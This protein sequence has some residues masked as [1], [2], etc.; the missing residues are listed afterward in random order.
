M[1]DDFNPDEYIKSKQ[2]DEFNPD[3]YIKN[4]GS[5]EF[6][7]D[8]YLNEK[9]KLETKPPSTITKE[10]LDKMPKWQ[11]WLLTN[12]LAGLNS[13]SYGQLNLG[14][15][16]GK[17][18]TTL[19]NK[20]HPI[21]N[22]AGQLEGFIDSPF[23]KGIT[24]PGKLIPKVI[25]NAPQLAKVA[26]FAEE[27]PKLMTVLKYL[28]RAGEGAAMVGA[29]KGDQGLG[30]LATGAGFNA[31][32]TKAPW[33]AGGLGIGAA[34]A[35]TSDNPTTERYAPIVGGGLGAL[36]QYL[37]KTPSLGSGLG[38]AMDRIQLNKAA[39]MKSPIENLEN[40]Y[41]S[42]G[43]NTP[44]ELRHE[45][46]LY[47]PTNGAPMTD[48]LKNAY[49]SL[50]QIKLN[51]NSDLTDAEKNILGNKLKEIPEIKYK[52]LGEVQENP[53]ELDKVLKIIDDM[54]KSRG[55]KEDAMK[56]LN[57]QIQTLRENRGDTYNPSKETISNFL[58]GRQMQ[59]AFTHSQRLSTALTK[60][61]G[62]EVLPE[63]FKDFYSKLL[64]MNE[65]VRA[66][67]LNKWM[68]PSE[69]GEVAPITRYFNGANEI[70]PADLNKM[71]QSGTQL[72]P[73]KQ[74]LVGEIQKLN[75]NNQ[76][77][78]LTE[79]TQQLG[80][81]KNIKGD[82]QNKSFDP[83]QGKFVPVP[84][85]VLNTKIDLRNLGEKSNWAPL[86]ELTNNPKQYQEILANYK[87]NP[88]KM[89]TTIRAL[90]ED[91][92]PN[93][94]IIKLLGTKTSYLDEYLKNRASNSKVADQ[95]NM[96]DV[97][98]QK[99][100][101]R[102]QQAQST[103][104]SKQQLNDLKGNLK[105]RVQTESEPHIQMLQNM[106]EGQKQSAI[107]APEPWY[108]KA[109]TELP[110]IKDAWKYIKGIPSEWTEKG[111]LQNAAQNEPYYRQ[112]YA[113]G[114]ILQN[115]LSNKY[116]GNLDELKN[117][118][119]ALPEGNMSSSMA[120]LYSK[121]LNSNY[122]NSNTNADNQLRQSDEEKLKNNIRQQR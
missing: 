9:P 10:N 6:N 27:S 111:K 86:A 84:Q 74:A 33:L 56:T 95:N 122:F 88:K 19:L 90:Q 5:E 89:E 113:K 110:L 37:T 13:S 48:K 107:K 11:Q 26:K 77:V 120:G 51:A 102:T 65:G 35:N 69:N 46:S 85:D 4:K 61:G 17:Q 3:E 97:Y 99:L 52:T 81:L 24:L 22:V 98:N 108:S 116:G 34:I 36:A 73:N 94:Q 115:D 15:E 68:Q 38:P 55:I 7:P 78:P 119:T 92:L 58:I 54:N 62:A 79:N 23:T 104:D 16:Q 28:T 117:M 47:K 18:L 101:E 114:N 71:Q 96:A 8:S 53:I 50:E 103:L 93:D 66:G 118:S 82:I 76:N 63:K 14:G 105:D 60:T 30:Q 121:M 80:L 25:Q 32:A 64:E 39:A 40:S 75:G 67:N 59:P 41:Q 44:P 45:P 29:Q 20:E 87:S 70:L 49:D 31:L 91:G 83:N 106:A 100:A 1:S 42:I 57:D 43:E 112:Q 12:T 2:S 21:A 109:I 72:F